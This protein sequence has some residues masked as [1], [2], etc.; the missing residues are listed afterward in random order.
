MY[1]KR[2]G[3]IVQEQDSKCKRCGGMPVEPISGASSA[4]AE[5]KDPW[6]STYLQRRLK[7][8]TTARPTSAYLPQSAAY[9]PHQ[10]D[11]AAEPRALRSGDR[12]LT[13]S[14]SMRSAAQGTQ[15]HFGI[16]PRFGDHVQQ[17]H[18]QQP[19]LQ[20]PVRDATAGT[21]PTSMYA[22]GLLDSQV[23]SAIQRTVAP[24]PGDS[25]QQPLRQPPRPAA[26]QADQPQQLRS[27][28]SQYFVSTASP[29]AS[30]AAANASR[31]R[32]ESL[33]TTPTSGSAPSPNTLFGARI[34]PKKSSDSYTTSPSLV[35]Q[36][37][38]AA[39][40]RPPASDTAPGAAAVAT[41]LAS[42]S[43]RP[44][45]NINTAPGDL[46]PARRYG[47]SA[48]HSSA[49]KTPELGSGMAARNVFS[50]FDTRK[51]AS[52]LSA[53]PLALGNMRSRSATLPD[54][55]VGESQPCTTCG[56]V[57]RPE[58]QRQFASKQ[59][60]VYCTDCYHSSY[61]R[62]HCAGCSKIVL[63]HGRPWV[64]HGDKVWHKLCIKC[65]T[66][67]KL[68]ITPLV[69]LDGM[70]T[71]EP[72]F[73]RE[74]PRATPRPMPR[75]QPSV[76]AAPIPA[77]SMPAPRT[78]RI[79]AP[80]A[81]AGPPSSAPRALAQVDLAALEQGAK[82]AAAS[83]PTPV[84]SEYGNALSDYGS[85]DVDT[86]ANKFSDMTMDAMRI[87]SPVEVAEKEGLPPPRT[88]VDPD[89]GSISRSESQPSPS[90]LRRTPISSQQ[91]S[92][93]EATARGLGSH[94]HSRTASASSAKIDAIKSMLNQ[95]V[96]PIDTPATGLYRPP[97]SPS[98]K[99]PNSPTARASS[100]RSV[101]F[102]IDQAPAFE[103]STT[104]E[105]EEEEE[106]EEEGDIERQDD[107]DAAEPVAPPRP[108]PRPPVQQSANEEFVD[109]PA[110]SL[111]DYV[112]S[113]ASSAKAKVR[114]PSVADTIKK[115]STAAFLKD[116]AKEA[117]KE[118]IDRSQLPELQDMIR[119]HQRE[120]PTDPTIPALDKHSRILKSRPRNNN[121]RRPSQSPAAI[122]NEL[123]SSTV[124]PEEDQSKPEDD[125]S[126]PLAPNQ[127]ARC[128]NPIE[129]TWFRL[130]D[131][132]QVHVECFTCQGCDKLIDDGVYVLE[133]GIEF[134]PACV[135]PSPP[136]VSVSPVPSAS[137]AKVRGPRAPRREET[138]DRCQSVLSGPRFQLTN[139][140][141]YHPECF[142]CA[143]CGQRFDEGSYVCFEGQEYHHQC[144]EKFAVN[145]AAGAG[146]PNEPDVLVCHECEQVIEGVFLRH[147]SA[148]FHPNCFCCND[149]ERAIT[150]G[151]PFGEISG[152]P[153]CESCLE[154]RAVAQQQQQ[155][156]QNLRQKQQQTHQPNAWASN[157]QQPY[158]PA[159]TGY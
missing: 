124:Q 60:V 22:G 143:G 33:N 76:D 94:T 85:P 25:Q 6:S 105:D 125:T 43:P 11:F 72:C 97:L 86:V 122:Q 51:P 59:G 78:S 104:E 132:R 8:S 20:R 131:G 30:L 89:L 74:H 146:V 145:N 3:N 113:K 45:A 24:Q 110:K 130:S 36:R 48:Q 102:Q 12:P 149:C 158:Y 136:V 14:P 56:V 58:E 99:N 127:C 117:P 37:P 115:F 107:E 83:I 38:Y 92:R 71:C 19:L 55:H 16:S 69:D 152:R 90:D 62:G 35:Q 147:N 54:L 153:C 70:P 41:T 82:Q 98:L 111:A 34:L 137:S 81:A 100:S 150:P 88:I 80:P 26:Q 103:G 144:V 49:P 13:G 121:R 114:M 18:Q 27:K 31:A 77:V 32:S 61:S 156:Q 75:E 63:T 57:L 87:M 148:A 47:A 5:R 28:W 29:Q 133:N 112:L 154:Q 66:C 17:Q 93:A 106:E 23:Q 126:R 7:P 39:V 79:D 123:Q 9:S 119:T 91:P 46:L 128:T 129:D 67:A 155:Q 10:D 96:T 120:P 138:C 84:I 64:Q 44:L 135:P 1:C 40:Q 42:P 134:H 68:L 108:A 73:M 52:P 140:K 141:Q 151:M 2:C 118:T 21:R 15:Q 4:A 53:S 157:R 109:E 159:K 95:S 65:R 142:A 101:S 116:P 139:G 50:S